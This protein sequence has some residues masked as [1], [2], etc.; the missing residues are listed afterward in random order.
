MMGGQLVKWSWQDQP[1][2]R[3][4]FFMM[5]PGTL[6]PLALGIG[7]RIQI[8]SAGAYTATYSAVGFNGFLLCRSITS[9]EA[10]HLS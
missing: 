3:L 8:L 5:R 4:M 9:D 1:A 2:M 7:S 10:F 6:L